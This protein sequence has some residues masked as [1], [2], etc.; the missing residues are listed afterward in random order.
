MK[1]SPRYIIISPVRNEAAHLPGTIQSIASQTI[2]PV[3]WI[4]V[5][6]GSTDNTPAILATAAKEHP[7]ITVVTRA[8]RGARKPGGGVIEAFYDGFAK[9]ADA[10]WDFIVKLDGDVSFERDYFERCFAAFAADATLGIAGGLVCNLKNGAL[11]AES[12]I[13]PEFHVRG[14][15]K[16]YRRTCWDQLGELIRAPGWDTLDELKA[17]ML[18][19]KT[20]TLRDIQLIHHR[21]AG[22]KDGTWTNW[23]KNGRANYVVGYHPA[24]MFLKA[25]SRIPR[26]PYCIAGLGPLV[27]FITGYLKRI[28]QISD[29]ALIHFLRREQLKRLFFQPS[30]WSAR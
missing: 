27:G 7:W 2:L 23:V 16:I 11:V 30:L 14:A 28:P 12:T 18:N 25:L 6:D 21:P 4:V 26:R 15:T 22:S 17:N 3:Q 8:D 13:D 10:N 1:T 20:R 24:F 5:D 19:W 29:K 9:I